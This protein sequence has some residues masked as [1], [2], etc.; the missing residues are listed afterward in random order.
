MSCALA[1][2]V[3]AG[4]AIAQEAPES[5]EGLGDIVVTAQKQEQN[6]QDVPISVTALSSD[7]LTTRGIASAQD[8]QGLLPGVTFQPNGDLFVT[9]RGI[10]TFNLQPGVD[11]AVAYTVD[12]IYIAHPAQLPTLL[13]DIE[14]V[15][16]LRGPQGTFLGRNAN[17][18]AVNFVTARPTGNFG[19]SGALGYG[20]YNLLSSE[21]TVNAPIAEGIAV[22]GAFATR[23]HDPYIADGH[24]D[25]DQIAARFRALIEPSDRFSLLATV[26]YNRRQ[27]NNIGVAKCPPHAPEA[28]CAGVPWRPFDGNDQANPNDFSDI[29]TWGV[30]AQADLTIGEF[31]TLTYIPSYRQGVTAYLTT[32]TRPFIRAAD[33]DRLH[34]Q[35]LRL[36]SQS[37]SALQWVVGLYYSR[38]RF[39][40]LTTNYWDTNTA[41][42]KSPDN[43]INYLKV[44]YYKA[45]SKAAFAQVT[46]PITAGL[47]VTGGIRYTD[48]SKVSRGSVNA[49]TGSV[50]SPVLL[51]IPTGANLSDDGFT[52][53]VGAEA[54]LG[55]HSMLYANVSTG[56]K[57]G[58]V[59]QVDPTI[60]LPTT[61]GPERI[62]AYQLGSKNRFL[63]G[64]LQV[65]AEAFYYDYKG[66]QTL[67]PSRQPNGLLYFLTVN[68][69][70]AR[71]YGGEME[72]SFLATPDDRIDASVALLDAEFTDFVVGPNNYTGNKPSNAPPY[73]VTAG[74]QRTFHVDNGGKVE[75]RVE[76]RLVGR[77]FVSANNLPL[78]IQSA[79][80]QSGANIG[81]TAPDGAWSLTA[82]I[83]NIENNGIIY[84]S[85]APGTRPESVAYPLP[86]RT[87]GI[88]LRAGL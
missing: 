5:D 62:T 63:A 7:D 71:F 11:S 48:E 44:D 60:G 3:S 56:L 68:S 33:N 69:Q 86:P 67:L 38:E 6:L 65:N 50:A 70:T 8:L 24:N 76:T 81:Y 26:D 29:E 16:A 28:A 59:N 73:T 1:A 31:A 46:V 51:S 47:R 14:R 88:T 20:N 36:S 30:Y 84:N 49:Y 66:F 85:T 34:S 10:G 32:P 57:S 45:E 75:A 64:R 58:G 18:G 17:A 4:S 35:E 43:V 77:H 53:R 74:Y 82:W 19:V 83:R 22:R 37:G 27:D 79:Y 87:F 39:E 41:I 13:F 52:W 40:R 55:P 80:M 23:K 12:G 42:P 54:D 15:E 21:V 72:A 25:E 9:V 78:T 2:L 61:Y